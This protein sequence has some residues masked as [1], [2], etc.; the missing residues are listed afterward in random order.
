[1]YVSPED[2]E[3]AVAYYVAAFGM[4]V[5][6]KTDTLASLNGGNF[7]LY[8]EVGANPGLHLQEFVSREKID[9]ESH[10]VGLGCQLLEVNGSDHSPDGF[11]VRDPF[12]LQYHVYTTDAGID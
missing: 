4:S 8:V 12:G 1:V 9:A 6:D 3:R 2:Y 11:Y 5:D 10:L 7:M